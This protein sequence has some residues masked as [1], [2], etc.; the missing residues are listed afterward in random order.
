MGGHLIR[1][2]VSTYKRLELHGNGLNTPAEVIEK[3]LNFYEEISG[4]QT[5]A[6]I[7]PKEKYR[8]LDIEFFPF[9]EAIFKDLLVANKRAWICFGSA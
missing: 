4:V 1:I 6:L 3:Y 5:Q 7:E 9:D 8:K 2:P